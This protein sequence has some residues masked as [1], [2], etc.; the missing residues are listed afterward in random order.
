MKFYHLSHTDLDGYSAQLV[1]KFYLKDVKFF[2]SNYGREINEKFN[3]ILA[4]INENLAK[5]SAEKSLVL[6]T[7]LNLTKEQCDEFSSALTNKNAKLFLLDHHQSGA[8]CAENFEWY[9]LDNSR[10]ATLITYDFFAGIYGGDENL[11]E[12][13]KMVNAVDIWLKDDRYFEFGKVCLG[14]VANAKEINKIMFPHLSNDY[15]F[16]LLQKANEF[17]WDSAAH[18]KLDDAV[19]SLKKSYFYAGFDDT[20]SNMISAFIVKHLSLQKEFFSINLGEFQAILTH[21][22][23]NTSVIGNDFLV[24]NPEFDFF[25]DISSKKTLSLRANGKVDVSLIAA[26]FFSGGGHKNASGGMFGAFK[27]SFDYEN[28]KS[29]VQNH[30]NKILGKTDEK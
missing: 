20:L 23:G 11:G 21:N 16:Y 29:Q 19:H 8:E 26:K 12:F 17:M 10:C 28:I 13:C 3:Q 14:L 7:D 18:I 2:N 9:F 30:I 4:Q 24:A 15:I 27:D 6:I 1:S 22:I 25:M 5:N